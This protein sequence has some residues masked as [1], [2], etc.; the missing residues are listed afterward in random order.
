MDL[1]SLLTSIGNTR[2]NPPDSATYTWYPTA[3]E[4][5]RSQPHYVNKDVK[6]GIGFQVSK[7]TFEALQ[8]MDARLVT[9][10]PGSCN[11]KHRHSHEAIFVLLSGQGEIIIDHQAMP[12]ELGCVASVPRWV[13]HQCRNTSSEAPLMLLAITNFGLTSAVLGNYDAKTRLKAGGVDAFAAEDRDYAHRFAHQTRP[14]NPPQSLSLTHTYTLSLSQL[15]AIQ[16][17]R[18]SSN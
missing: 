11:E 4:S 9:I 1:Q 16:S 14:I 17:A 10:A 2:S 5:D 15:Q 13:V 12:L 7:L 3:A 8:V 18:N 6:L